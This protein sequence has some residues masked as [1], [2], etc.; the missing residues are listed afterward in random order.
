MKFIFLIF[1]VLMNNFYVNK[2]FL[3]FFF[4]VI[5]FLLVVWFYFFILNY[6]IYSFLSFSD[7]GLNFEIIGVEFFYGV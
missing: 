4:C 5:M 3:I 2:L 7:K 1:L 6:I